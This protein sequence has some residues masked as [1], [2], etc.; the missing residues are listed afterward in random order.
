ML[1]AYPLVRAPFVIGAFDRSMEQGLGID[2]AHHIPEDASRAFRAHPISVVDFA[3]GIGVGGVVL[4]DG[5]RVEFAKPGGVPLTLVLY[6]PASAG[7]SGAEAAHPILLQMYGGAW[8]RGSP[9]DNATF[10]S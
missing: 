9:E 4:A 1:C 10:A 3:R 5:M 7:R 8:Q 6:R 2:Y